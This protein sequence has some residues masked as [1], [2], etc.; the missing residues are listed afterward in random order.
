MH[1]ACSRNSD[2]CVAL[3]IAAGADVDEPNRHGY[4]PVHSASTCDDDDDK[5]LAQLIASGANVNSVGY[6]EFTPLFSA[7]PCGS[8]ACI[9]L[10]VGAGADVNRSRRVCFTPV[11]CVAN[12]IWHVCYC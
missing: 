11:T 12:F 9:S 3:L 10:L 6:D 8:K 1:R 7:F 2:K 4:P 5:W